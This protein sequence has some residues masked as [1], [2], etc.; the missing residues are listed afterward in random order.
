MIAPNTENVYAS[1]R[2][3]SGKHAFL[4]IFGFFVLPY[5]FCQTYAFA[6]AAPASA[7]TAAV[8]AAVLEYAEDNELDVQVAIPHVRDVV[9]NGCDDPHIR[10]ILTSKRIRGETAPVRI[11]L[12]NPEGDLLKRLNLAVHVKRFDTVM[13][14]L[15]DIGRGDTL[16]VDDMALNRMEVTGIGDFRRSADELVG[17]CAKAPIK[18]GEII[19]SR[20]LRPA[21]LVRRGDRI[22]VKAVVGNVELVSEGVARQDGGKGEKIRVYSKTTRTSVAGRVYDA[23]TVLVG[24]AGD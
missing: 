10:A 3:F 9:V 15:R 16:R 23:K 20:A 5:A 22:V 21:P 2:R 11:E 4:L 17:R 19:R 8:E 12:L 1:S 7:I 18:V 6:G 24:K 13:I 14:A